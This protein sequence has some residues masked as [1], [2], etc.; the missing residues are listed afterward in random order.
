MKRLLGAFVV[1][2]VL[3]CSMNVSIAA[4]PTTTEHHKLYPYTSIMASP[5]SGDPTGVID[6]AAALESIKANQSNT[7]TISI[8]KGTFK[9][10]TNLTIP[11]GMR[12]YFE[13]GATFSIANGVVL[14]IDGSVVGDEDH[15]VFTLVGTGS[16][17][18]NTH[19]IFRL[20]SFSSLSA[21][22]ASI[23]STSATL[24]IDKN[25]SVSVD[26][27]FPTT[28][29]VQIEKGNILTIA[30]TKTL[31]IN[32]PL[33]AGLYQIFSCTGTGTVAFGSGS[34]KELQVAW[35]GSNTTAITTALNAAPSGSTVRFNAGQSYIFSPTTTLTLTGKSLWLTCDPGV[36]IDATGATCNPVI[37]L[38]GT[39]ST[40]TL[41]RAAVSKGAT[42]I[43]LA[44]AS[45]ALFS[46]GDMYQLSTSNATPV[47]VGSGELWIANSGGWKGELGEVRL[48]NTTPGAAY[49]EN[50]GFAKDGYTAANTGIGKITPITGGLINFN[51]KGLPA[52]YIMF[53][54]YYARDF[55]IENCNI[56]E[57]GVSLCYVLRG[58]VNDST[59]TVYKGSGGNAYAL[60]VN[61]CQDVRVDKCTLLGGFQAFSTG[62]WEPVRST[63]VTN[64]T[65]A[66]DPAEGKNAIAF[67]E[68]TENVTV[69]DCV[70]YGGILG[71]VE[72]ENVH[73]NKL[74]VGT[75]SFTGYQCYL[76]NSRNSIKFTD[77]EIYCDAAFD[78][79]STFQLY[80]DLRNGSE[81]RTIDLS[82]NKL[83]G[84]GAGIRVELGNN[85]AGSLIT[86]LILNNTKIDLLSVAGM[87]ISFH[88]I[89][90]SHRLP[91]LNLQMDNMTLHYLNATG[92]YSQDCTLYN[93]SMRGTK[94][95]YNSVT[96][97]SYNIHMTD[98]T[99]ISQM[100]VDNNLFMNTG[101]MSPI[102]IGG[103]DYIRFTQNQLS[104]FASSGGVALT[105]TDILYDKNFN[106]G[107]VV[108]NVSLTGRYYRSIFANGNVITWGATYPGSGTWKVGDQVIATTPAA[109]GVAGWVCT[110]AGA[111]PATA[112]WAP[113]ACGVAVP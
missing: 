89:D 90:T 105:G 56:R 6:C 107:S 75:T 104:N 29:S 47:F 34:I 66:S 63:V 112:K 25:V 109:S 13:A 19:K 96:A 74:Y 3:L 95:Y 71:G 73:H 7:G 58:S 61:S 18:H 98:T 80:V 87:P 36:E 67:H 26:T 35:F 11:A 101:A 86:D 68:N 103:A 76:N 93:V 40:F 57:G 39:T 77:N 15:Q 83:Y 16:V 88:G 69:S 94:H 30:T 24:Y 48:V 43:N 53:S 49:I 60:A 102:T 82:G 81:V 27:T 54:V 99:G 52:N 91:I 113:I 108:G 78:G 33:D 85:T 12:L 14:T 28:V 8:P 10:G 21:A 46:A 92:I 51:I 4:Y 64:S 23:G 70:A 111:A 50:K 41:L 2:L 55:L 42:G 100:A 84:Y 32:G 38:K 17:V 106:I 20:S 65:L 110:T 72:G 31:T 37:A 97:G 1:V 45:A 9:V 22:I 62:G 5:Y 44:D 59:I 79:A